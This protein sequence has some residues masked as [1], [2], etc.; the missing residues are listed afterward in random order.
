MRARA[1]ESQARS[2]PCDP[3]C[4]IPKVV[5]F[6]GAAEVPFHVAASSSLENDESARFS[7]RIRP[8]AKKTMTGSLAGCRVGWRRRLGSAAC[9]G[10]EGTGGVHGIAWM[11]GSARA[12]AGQSRQNPFDGMETTLSGALDGQWSGRN[13]AIEGIRFARRRFRRSGRRAGLGRGRSG[14]SAGAGARPTR[15]VRLGR[16][17]A[18][19]PVLA[20][21]RQ[22]DNADRQ[23]PRRTDGA[24]TGAARSPRSRGR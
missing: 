24:R 14:A 3:R 13:H 10:R 8:A 12:R 4:S 21:A 22:A 18:G 11:N 2:A 16:R 15:A 5:P 9:S 23:G 1:C 20:R 17:R 7:M 19:V 6:Q